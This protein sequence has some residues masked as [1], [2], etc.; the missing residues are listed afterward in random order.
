MALGYLGFYVGLYALSKA[1]SG[2]A[3][4]AAA[5][6][7]VAANDGDMPS[8]ESPAFGEWVGKDGNLEKLINSA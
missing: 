4:P 7:A 3:K 2:K 1:F 5:P 6:A 8:I